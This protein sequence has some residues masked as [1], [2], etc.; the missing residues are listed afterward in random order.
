MCLCVCVFCAIRVRG[1]PP[2]GD[3]PSARISLFTKHLRLLREGALGK[4]GFTFPGGAR[5]EDRAG[6]KIRSISSLSVTLEGGRFILAADEVEL[7]APVDLVLSTAAGEGAFTAA[8]D[9]EVRTYPLP[10]EIRGDGKDLEF[11]VTED[12]QRYARD[13]AI[14]E[15]GPVGRAETEAVEALSLLVRARLEFARARAFHRRSHFCDLTHC[16]VYKGRMP[17]NYDPPRGPVWRVDPSSSGEP[18]PF[19]A[20]C[21]GHTLGSGVFGRRGGLDGVKDRLELEGIPLCGAGDAAWER[22]IRENELANILFHHGN[23]QPAEPLRLSRNAGLLVHAEK[24]NRALALPLEEFRLRVNR[25]KGWNFI[26]SNNYTLSRREGKDAALFLFS[27]RGLG[28]GAGLCQQGACELARRGY[29]RYE[30]LEHYFPSI[31]F[32]CDDGESF[33]SP[34]LCHVVFSLDDGRAEGVSFERLPSRNMPAGSLFKLIVSLYLA[35]ER[36]DLLKEHRYTCKGRSGDPALPARCWK[37]GGHGEMTAASALSRSCNLYFASL[38]RQIDPASFLAFCHRIYAQ[39]GIHAT[40]P[41]PGSQME[42]ARLLS[43]LD[44]RVK[45]RVTDMIALVGLFSASAGVAPGAEEIRKGIDP[46]LF[47]VIQQSL[48]DTMVNGTASSDL[49]PYG[50]RYNCEPLMRMD[51]RLSGASGRTRRDAPAWGKTSTVIS[52]TNRACSYGIFIGASGGR[53]IVLIA[54]KTNGHIASRWAGNILSMH[55]AGK[56]RPEK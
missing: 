49:K 19:H 8:I 22:T 17:G 35:S 13:A 23:A 41:P 30:I 32:L 11:I 24:G 7:G 3:A 38:C 9:R 40:I 12:P 48:A 36:P 43:G 37:S 21:G 25:V 10:L 14:A 55:G 15:L 20:S 31:R 28:H 33:S 4:L 47:A 26:R 56:D 18:P 29:S 45:L 39:L 50:S 34:Y 52:G 16:Q 6:G 46:G 42:F 2:A 53:G 27:G 44:F 54:R 5:A 1:A 51:A